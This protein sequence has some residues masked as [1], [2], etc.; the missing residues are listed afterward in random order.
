M[1]HRVKNSLA[2]VSSMPN[3]QARHAANAAVTEHLNE[4]SY[5][6]TAIAKAHERLSQGAQIERMEVGRKAICKDLDAARA[7]TGPRQ[8]SH[9]RRY[10]FS[11]QFARAHLDRDGSDRPLP[12]EVDTLNARPKWHS[13]GP[14]A[15][16]PAS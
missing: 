12:R 6:V 1:N 10:R 7:E 14:A 13:A 3:L 5:R 11:S 16:E 9:C 4:A 8:F 2:I 15:P